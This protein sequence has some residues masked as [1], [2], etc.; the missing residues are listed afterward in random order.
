M[1]LS[2]QQV[3]GPSAYPSINQAESA[4]IQGCG[5]LEVDHA[6]L[7]LQMSTAFHIRI[8]LAVMITKS[9]HG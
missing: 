3:F 8:A 4:M 5:L 1:V 2:F 6:D 7:N 9:T